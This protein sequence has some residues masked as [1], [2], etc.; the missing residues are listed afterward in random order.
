MKK[1]I[2]RLF[3]PMAVVMAP[4]TVIVPKVSAGDCFAGQRI[5]CVDREFNFCAISDDG[6]LS[7][8]PC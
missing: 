5:V 6:G 8:V 1:L 2:L 4:L 3:M 7:W